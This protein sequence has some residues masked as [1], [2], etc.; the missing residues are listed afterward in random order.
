MRLFRIMDD[1]SVFL[2]FGNVKTADS[3]FR[4]LFGLVFSAPLK[5]GEGLLIDSCSSIHTFW[6]RYPIDVLFLDSNNRVIKLFEDL[7]PFRVTPF[8]K[9]VAKTIELKS[10]TVKACSINTGDCLK[11]V[12]S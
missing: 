7:K 6:M 5:E 3:F 10:G 8:I 9:G 2:L 12:W 1:G 11:L 4:K